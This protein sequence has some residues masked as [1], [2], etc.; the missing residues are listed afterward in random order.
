MDEFK[1]KREAFEGPLDLLLELVERKKLHI[2]DISLASVT[3]EYLRHIEKI[4]A[5]Q[6]ADRAEF[7]VIAATLLLIKSRS[8]LPN[9]D[10]TE[11]E[12]GSIADLERRLKMLAIIREGSVEVA[13]QF[14][15][16]MIFCE[17]N[18][19]Q[20]PRLFS[21]RDDDIGGGENI[22]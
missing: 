20:E 12:E 4:P 3:E 8:L 22:A 10:L 15:K 5:V 9:L 16:K 21:T 17:A 1:I 18:V 7:I 6:I 2:N 14:G 19:H 11:E 13:R